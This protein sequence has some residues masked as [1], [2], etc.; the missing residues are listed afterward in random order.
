MK[1][2]A[3]FVTFAGEAYLALVENRSSLSPHVFEKGMLWARGE[4]GKGREE[5]ILKKIGRL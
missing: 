1:V 5:V 2:L 3:P 4:D